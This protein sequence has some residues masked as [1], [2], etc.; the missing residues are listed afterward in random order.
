[1][2]SG[3]R[4]VGDFLRAH[5]MPADAAE[6]DKRLAVMAAAGGGSDGATRPS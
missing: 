6:S 4:Q 2:V 1:V 3:L 5:G